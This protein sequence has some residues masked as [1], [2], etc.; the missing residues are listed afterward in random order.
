MLSSSVY[1]H[2]NLDCFIPRRRVHSPLWVPLVWMAFFPLFYWFWFFHPYESWPLFGGWWVVVVRW[3]YFW[4]KFWLFS[5][6]FGS[7][8]KTV[9]GLFLDLNGPYLRLVSTQKKFLRTTKIEFFGEKYAIFSKLVSVIWPILG[10][11]NTFFWLFESWFGVVQKLF[12]HCF[13]P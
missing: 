11:K 9:W 12:G 2:S 3:A 10:P 13:W 4:D 8:F 1:Q 6:L 5:K 7:C